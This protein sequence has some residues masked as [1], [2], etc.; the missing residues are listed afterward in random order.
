MRLTRLL[1]LLL[2]LLLKGLCERG[3]D[4]TGADRARTESVSRHSCFSP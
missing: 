3:R 4:G 2:R 1:V